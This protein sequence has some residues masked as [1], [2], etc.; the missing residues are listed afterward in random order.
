M[1][2]GGYAGFG[3]AWKLKKQLRRDEAEL[4]VMV[5]L[6][7]SATRPFQDRSFDERAS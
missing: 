4:A 6:R 3:T 5:T 7:G 2:G 1:I